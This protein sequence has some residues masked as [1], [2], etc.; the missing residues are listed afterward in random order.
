[1]GGKAVDCNWPNRR[2][3]QYRLM[4]GTALQPHDGVWRI[5]GRSHQPDPKPRHTAR[6]TRHPCKRHCAG[7]YQYRHGCARVA[8]D[9]G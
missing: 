2:D 9:E 3:R 7:C 8:G 6:P 4:G 5:E 1:M